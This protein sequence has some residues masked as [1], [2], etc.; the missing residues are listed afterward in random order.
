MKFRK[1]V[2]R[3]QMVWRER[4][5]I[6]NWSISK[7]TWFGFFK[8]TSPCLQVPAPDILNFAGTTTASSSSQVSE[9]WIVILLTSD[10]SNLWLA[11]AGFSM[12]I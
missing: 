11:S 5:L 8:L 7:A 6:V 3:L 4:A 2:A 1:E 12:R 9:P 10:I